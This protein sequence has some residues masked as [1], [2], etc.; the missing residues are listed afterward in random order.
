MWQIS[1]PKPRATVSGLTLRAAWLPNFL[2]SPKSLVRAPIISPLQSLQLTKTPIFF[3]YALNVNT[4]RATS[5]ITK[6]NSN[7]DQFGALTFSLFIFINQQHISKITLARQVASSPWCG[8]WAKQ[9]REMRLCF[10]T[11]QKLISQS[12]RLSFS[13]MS[14][15]IR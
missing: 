5:H 10:Q 9:I 11:L 14:S 4:Q 12:S 15:I 7:L 2:R 13:I 8:G 6:A 1:S 3:T